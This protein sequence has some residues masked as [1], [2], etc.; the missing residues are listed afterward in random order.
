ME[1]PDE[2]EPFVVVEQR[3]TDGSFA[4]DV[5]GTRD[6]HDIRV[7]CLSRRQANDLADIINSAAGVEVEAER[8]RHYREG[9]K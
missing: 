6:G 1:T 5:F 7:C 4:Y 3:L 9:C 2:P 8:Y